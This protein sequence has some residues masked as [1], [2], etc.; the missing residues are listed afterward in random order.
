MRGVLRAAVLAV[1][2]AVTGAVPG[3]A[4]D[5]ASGFH[6][7]ASGRA[8]LLLGSNDF[9]DGGPGAEVAGWWGFGRTGRLGVRVD[10]GF[11][12]LTDDPNEFTRTRA[13]N[14]LTYLTAGPTLGV[15][16]GPLFLYLRPSLGIVANAQDFS[17]D[18]GPGGARVTRTETAWAG[19]A[20]LA[21]GLRIFLT[22]GD[23]AVGL[24][25]GGGFLHAGE[26]DFATAGSGTSGVTQDDVTTLGLRLGLTFRLP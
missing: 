2:L 4:Q 3:R 14:T 16:S 24:D 9:L 12:A 25:L 17:S 22:A 10:L 26:L 15:G 13:D 1:L 19:A 18:G 11:L 6:L 21:A 7:G 23:R 5:R 8:A 20:G